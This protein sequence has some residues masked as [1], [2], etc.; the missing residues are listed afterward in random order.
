MTNTDFEVIIIG[1]G[2]AGMSAALVLGRS[3]INTLILNTEQARNMVTTHSHGFLTRDGVHPTEML[4]IAKEQL[5]KYPAVTYLKEKATGM[6]QN[7]KGFTITSPNGSFSSK[8]VVLATGQKDNI[9]QSSI[10][11]LVEVYGRSVYPC[12]FCD[13][14]ELADKR[15]AV[16]STA[17]IAPHFAKVIGH[18]SNDVIVFNNGDKVTDEQ[19]ISELKLN[20]IG[21][22]DQEIQE[23]R[24][25]DGKL[26]KVILKDGSTI[27]REG[28]FLS[29]TGTTESVDFAQKLNISTVEGHFGQPTYEVDDN[30]ETS[31]RG[32]YIIGDSRVGFGGVARSVADGSTVGAAITHQVIDERWQTS[33]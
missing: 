16:F 22:V 2:P 12:P 33:E 23:L 30:M 13:G 8:R 25:A 3:R 4:S 21:L 20:G 9:G 14:F 19:L 31:M 11:G 32:L 17:D 28:G 7:P 1:G 6:S 10:P 5:Q 24:S 26:T 29:D 18:W 27:E 15:L